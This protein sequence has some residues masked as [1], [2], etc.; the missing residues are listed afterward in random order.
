MGCRIFI[1]FVALAALLVLPACDNSNPAGEAGK[2]ATVEA[3]T[4]PPGG[5]AGE[6]GE[7]ASEEQDLEALERSF[8]TQRH[9][10]D[11]DAIRKR[12]YIRVLV[13]YSK[14]FF[15]YEGA[16]P[17]GLAY[18]FMESFAK[19]LRKRPG[20]GKPLQLTVIY[21]PTARDR[22]IPGIVEG[23]GDIAIAGLTA[24]PGRKSEVDFATHSSFPVAEVLVT[25]PGAPRLK[26]IDDLS[27]KRVFIRSS[28]S[29]YETLQDLNRRLRSDGKPEVKIVEADENLE[30][31]DILE[32]VA[33]GVEKATVVDDYLARFWSESMDG[34]T[35][36]EDIVV[37]E[38]RLLG[39]VV[40][41]NSPQLV[42]ALTAFQKT[43]GLGTL[44]GN[45]VF[46]RYFKDNPWVQN[47]NASVDRKRFEKA[48]PLFSKYG[49]V[50]DF[51]VLLLVAQ[52]YQES[53]LN[54]STRNR[55]GA[56]GVMQIKPSTAK[57]D[58][59]NIVDVKTSM[60]NNIHA[61][62]KYLRHLADDYFG[63][64]GITPLNR[65][66]FAIA[67]YNAGPTRV[68]ALRRKAEA[69][70][71]DPNVWFNN[72]ELVS[73]REVG[74]QNVDYVRNIMKY[75]MA[76]RL[77]AELDKPVYPQ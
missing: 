26:T 36:R 30:V 37:A 2:A 77:A 35:V 14:T 29:Y 74:R 76:F 12:G 49:K 71:L 9:T 43:H 57:G 40:R 13:P 20:G 72:V 10:G 60:D 44:F 75:W 53:K 69:Q 34:I 55:S 46:K 39:P 17:R 45:V 62:V 73:A 70:G 23:L 67:A 42:A 33:N 41:K 22:L 47:P 1:I 25:G 7:S 31:E 63:D 51:D 65:H 27:G 4:D 38:G 28:S 50:Y 66:L 16:R 52:G 58:P 48:L 54:Q 24:T 64:P 32:L 19:E 5:T 8:R 61:G 18:D 3:E 21:L 6:A 11:L 56:V 59:V 15:F 68:Q